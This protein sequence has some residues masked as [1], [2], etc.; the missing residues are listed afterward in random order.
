ME[1]LINY[2]SKNQKDEMRFIVL[3][4]HFPSRHRSAALSKTL[5]GK[6]YVQR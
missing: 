1:C 6:I 2:T 4:V 3:Y 5:N